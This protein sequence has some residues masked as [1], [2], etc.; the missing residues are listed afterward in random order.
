MATT[1]VEQE[2]VIRYDQ[3]DRVL[4]LWTA[5]PAEAKRWARLGYDVEIA[6]RTPAGEPRSWKTQGPVEAL[7]L[8]KVVSGQVV[9]RRRGAGFPVSRRKL[10]VSDKGT[11]P[12][13]VQGARQ[14]NRPP[15]TAN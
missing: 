1:K 13:R 14:P 15:D 11:R 12:R 7:R 5:I 4:H 2:T 9:K 3:E 6:G 10:A 8:R